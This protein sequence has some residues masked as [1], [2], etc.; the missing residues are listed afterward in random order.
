MGKVRMRLQ[1]RGRVK[2]AIKPSTR[3]IAQKIF[4]S[5]Q[6]PTRFYCQEHASDPGEKNA[7]VHVRMR[8]C[9][10]IS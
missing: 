3:K 1:T 6:P 9:R 4:F 5:K 2:S 10:Q 7:S 8:E